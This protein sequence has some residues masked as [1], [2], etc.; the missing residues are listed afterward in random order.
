M[1]YVR[2]SPH[3]Y[4]SWAKKGCTGWSYKDVLPYFKKAEN[5]QFEE[6][7]DWGENHQVIENLYNEESVTLWFKCIAISKS[8]SSL[9][10]CQQFWMDLIDS[11]EKVLCCHN[12]L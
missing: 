6:S 3:D 9:H 7:P 5:F 11:Y 8:K 2:G 4:D 10:I 1:M 12:N